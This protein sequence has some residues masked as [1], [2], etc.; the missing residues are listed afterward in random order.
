MMYLSK[1]V[2]G[3]ILCIISFASIAATKYVP[4]HNITMFTITVDVV[5]KNEI[6]AKCKLLGTSPDKTSMACARW[7]IKKNMCHVI[8]PEPDPG[9][10]VVKNE[11]LFYWGHEL[12]HCVKGHYHGL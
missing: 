1:V 9:T 12:M 5:P 6:N 3:C 7:N 2:L 10:G 11:V 8:V 4:T